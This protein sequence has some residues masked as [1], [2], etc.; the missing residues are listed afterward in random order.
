MAMNY[1]EAEL[2]RLGDGDLAKIVAD[3]HAVFEKR[4]PDLNDIVLPSAEDQDSQLRDAMRPFV[5]EYSAAK[6]HTPDLIDHT[7]QGIWKVIGERVGYEYQVPACDRTPE[8]LAK[9]QEKGRAVLLLP[10]DIYTSNGLVRLGKAF[11]LIRSWTT[12]PKQIVEVSHRSVEGGSIDIEMSPDAPYITSR[13]YREQELVDRIT[14]DGKHGMRLPTYL[15]GSEFSQL[16]TGQY[17]DINTRSRLPGSYCEGRVLIANFNSEGKAYVDGYR[18]P[19]GH[20]TVLGGRS[21]G[22]TKELKSLIL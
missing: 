11:P 7:W 13:G 4:H 20:G 15:V 18:L 17:F 21:E 5:Q 8:E 16:L 14:A 2:R 1:T 19:Q 6:I 12:D 9:L 22:V 3:V 10:S